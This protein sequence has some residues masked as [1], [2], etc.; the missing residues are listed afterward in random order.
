MDNTLEFLEYGRKKTVV[1]TGADRGL[2]LALVK[3]YLADGHKVF[4]GKYRINWHKL[5]ELKEE[6]GDQLEIVPLDVASDESVAKAKEIILSKTDKIDI[7]L[8]VAGI[9]MENHPEDGTIK[10]EKL[11][12]D[13]MMTQF[14]VNALGAIRVT[15]ALIH[16]ILNSF[17]QIVCNVSSEAGS[18]R[19]C[20]RPNQFGYCMSKAALNMASCIMLNGARGDGLQVINVHPGWMQS[21][22]GEPI[23]ADAPYVEPA[24]PGEVKFY[25]TP[26]ITAKGIV[27]L[28][29]EPERFSARMPG[30]MTYRG[31]VLQY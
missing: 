16:A 13:E 5:E 29:Q 14:N 20:K 21:V 9:W 27:K 17:D 3:Q 1:I 11:Y 6:Y 7:L 12:F 28:L 8:N 23:D 19:D 18:L 10:S 25:T 26:E 2:G 22:I 4:A 30:Y 31:D 15:N 24:K